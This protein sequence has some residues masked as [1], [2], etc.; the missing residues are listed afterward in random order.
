[1]TSRVAGD[2][3]LHEIKAELFKALGHPS[4]VQVLE[5]LAVREQSVSAL[6]IATRSEPSTLSTHLAVLR[7]AGVV[8]TRREGTT[9]HYRL[10]DPS[11]ADFLAAA[12]TFL[13]RTL[14]QQA[15]VLA[16]LLAEEP[17]G[18]PR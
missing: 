7:R 14:A 3:P 11:V 8:H 4:R 6:L 5:L 13:T 9:V 18:V 10:A 2:R 1:M 17:A 12:R 15:G 16:D